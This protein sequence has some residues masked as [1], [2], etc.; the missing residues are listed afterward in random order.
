MRVLAYL[1]DRAEENSGQGTSFGLMTNALS[2]SEGRVRNACRA[3][4]HDGLLLV[5]ARF[6]EDGGQRAN[7]YVLTKVGYEVLRSGIDRAAR[8]AAAQPTVIENCEAD[9]RRRESSR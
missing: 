2:L 3:L 4:Q 7:R 6:D 9:I 1:A 8:K 5:E